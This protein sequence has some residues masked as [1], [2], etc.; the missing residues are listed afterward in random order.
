MFTPSHNGA[1]ARAAKLE[2]LHQRIT[3]D[4]ALP[5]RARLLAGVLLDEGR[6]FSKATNAEIVVQ[7]PEY[8]ERSIQYG[9]RD[10]EASGYGN[11]KPGAY[12]PGG[13]R[14]L[15]PLWTWYA[16]LHPF[17]TI[18]ISTGTVAVMDNETGEIMMTVQTDSP[19][20][21]KRGGLFWDELNDRVSAMSNAELGEMRYNAIVMQRRDSG[22]VKFWRVQ[23]R[24]YAGELA[25]RGILQPTIILS[26]LRT[27][28][29]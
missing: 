6:L 16:V 25:I 20:A 11:R 17:I 7:L 24:V 12:M 15:P 28:K 23:E 2:I 21:A 9:F 3:D 18:D 19:R 26:R 29:I 27:D 1:L 4:S 13:P 22:H 14:M 5:K 8:K 10:L